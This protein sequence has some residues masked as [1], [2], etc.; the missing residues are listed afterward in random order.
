MGEN[1]TSNN[2]LNFIKIYSIQRHSK[3]VKKHYSF[4]FEFSVLSADLVYTHILDKWD[5]YQFFFHFRGS[6]QKKP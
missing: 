5:S 2:W 6:N 4:K 1:G 3:R